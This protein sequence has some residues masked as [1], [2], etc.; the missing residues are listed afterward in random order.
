[1]DVVLAG[2]G[3]DLVGGAVDDEGSAT[4]TVGIASGDAAKEGVLFQVGLQGVEPEHNIGKLTRLVRRSEGDDDAAEVGD[5]GGDAGGIGEG[6]K[7]DGLTCG[8]L[9]PGCGGDGGGSGGGLRTHEKEKKEKE[10]GAVQS[11][12]V[13]DGQ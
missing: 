12:Q 7:L 10:K 2:I 5:A 6:E 9:A 4:D 1:M 11:R 3:G 13:H 8:C